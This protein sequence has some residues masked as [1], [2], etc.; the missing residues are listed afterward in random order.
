MSWNVLER[1]TGW[2]RRSNTADGH[3]EQ[4]TDEA[5]DSALFYCE[6]CDVT[7]ISRDMETCPRCDRPVE[8]VPNERELDRFHVH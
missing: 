5:A 6:Q 4:E 2:F 1:I 7:L 8:Q 3:E